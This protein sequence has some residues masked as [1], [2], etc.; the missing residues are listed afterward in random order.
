VV[1]LPGVAA[2]PA[3]LRGVVFGHRPA[4]SESG[5]GGGRE[6]GRAWVGGHEEL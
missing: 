3:G 5:S 6:R 1:L 4:A 2:P